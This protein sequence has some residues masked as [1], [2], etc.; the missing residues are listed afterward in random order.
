M[1]KFFLVAIA[2]IFVF[3]LAQCSTSKT[4]V[5]PEKVSQLLS[6]KSFRFFAEKANPSGMDAVNV[7]NAM[8]PAAS[9]QILNL[10]PGYG[11]DFTPKKITS[12]LPYF[13]RMYKASMDPQKNAYNFT[14]E[15][16]S[17]DDS[18][19][20]TKKAVFV[21]NVNDAQNIIRMI[22]EIFPNGRAYLSIDSNDRQL[23]SYDG[24]VDSM[25]EKD[26]KSK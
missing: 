17:I 25:P 21:Y 13:G 15:K 5:S 22:L 14:V 24:Y 6:T 7:M 9:T 4:I 12:N 26:E 16:F 1:K 2:L 20:S 18:K 3:L 10:Q 19:S 8:R 11:V 23:I